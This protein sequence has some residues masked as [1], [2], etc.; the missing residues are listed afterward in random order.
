MRTTL[1]ALSFAAGLGVIT[2][3]S[4]AAPPYRASRKA[5]RIANPI[6]RA[7]AISVTIRT[8]ALR[9]HDRNRVADRL[10][11]EIDWPA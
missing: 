2:C 6:R 4:A 3:Q 8:A 7:P 9:Q 1:A 5:R 10:R 11:F